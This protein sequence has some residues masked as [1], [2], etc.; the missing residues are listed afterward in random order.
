MPFLPF[1]GLL[2][3]IGAG[4][5]ATLEETSGTVQKIVFLYIAGAGVGSVVQTVL[6]GAQASVG[7]AEVAIVSANTSK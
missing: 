1:G 4:C 5:M 3:A 2:I 6:M 7:D